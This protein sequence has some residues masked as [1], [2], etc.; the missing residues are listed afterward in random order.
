MSRPRRASRRERRAV[1]MG[2]HRAR[3]ARSQRSTRN[4]RAGV[5]ATVPARRTRRRSRAVRA[6][7]DARSDVR[8]PSRARAGRRRTRSGARWR[9]HGETTACAGVTGTVVA[10]DAG[11]P[12]SGFLDVRV[13]YAP[14]A[15]AEGGRDERTR[16]GARRRRRRRRR[17]ETRTFGRIARFVRR[18]RCVR[19]V[20]SGCDCVE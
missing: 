8:A 9:K 15:S 11:T 7:T 16:R 13:E 12:E 1:A 19:V 4:G 10:P 5:R 20:E 3:R 2:V 14:Q 18:T 6:G 17:C